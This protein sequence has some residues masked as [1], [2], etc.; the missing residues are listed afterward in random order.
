MIDL[1][2]KNAFL[3]ML[4]VLLCSPTSHAEI[5]L[6]HT[7]TGIEGDAL[8]N[9]EQRLK[10]QRKTY[11][12]K[13]SRSMAEHLYLDAENEI[14]EAVKPYGYFNSEVSSHLTKSGDNWQATHTVKAG[15]LTKL[16]KISINVHGPGKDTAEIQQLLQDFPL[17]K[18][19][20]FT[21]KSYENAK[22]ILLF[23]AINHGFINAVIDK[24]Q[25]VIDIRDNSA[26]VVLSLNTHQ[27]HYFGTT[28]YNNSTFDAS[29][30]Q[31]FAPYQLGQPFSRMQVAAFQENLANSDYFSHVAA[32]P[33][34]IQ[35]KQVP[36]EVDLT[37]RKPHQYTYGVGYDTDVGPSALFGI[38]FNQLTSNGHTLNSRAKLSMREQ[39]LSTEY[40][41]PGKNPLTKHAVIGMDINTAVQQNTGDSRTIKF[42][43][44]DIT[45]SAFWHSSLGFNA[46]LERSNPAA[47]RAYN[48]S[49][50]YPDGSWTHMFKDIDALNIKDGRIQL[51][52]AASTKAL[53]SS[54]SFIQGDLSTNLMHQLGD[55]TRVLLRGKLG[56][57][58]SKDFNL[59][60]LS[61]KYAAGGAR[62]VRG[63][64][65]NDIGPG[66]ILRLLSTELQQNLTGNWYVIGFVDAGTA[67]NEFKAAM[68]KSIGTGVLYTT[69]VGDA[70]LS[71]A[72]AIDK[73]GKPICFQF[74]IDN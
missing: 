14:L 27:R 33:G 29:F 18:G 21:A 70:K 32:Q 55:S 36:V 38:K 4:A 58:V 59:M 17:K 61:M 24:N 60:P 48:S 51:N 65:Y 28:H 12:D 22:Q 34:K 42:H 44:H 73:P 1:G 10:E 25:V 63:Y 6:S 57:T 52:L 53:G 62:S 41:I 64:A 11:P 49:L 5:Q 2:K 50:L 39:E 3:L 71:I 40:V 26:Q 19:D 23:E 72:K 54:I 35:A 66:K 46:L 15:P 56:I 74:S 31:R 7:L 68:Y 30:L 9:A 67:D 69:P 45:K 37:L 13:L 43:V 8:H 16:T 20:T 47:G